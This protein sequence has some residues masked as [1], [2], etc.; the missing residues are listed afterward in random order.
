[1]DETVPTSDTSPTG[2]GTNKSNKRPLSTSQNSISEISHVV[3]PY[4]RG[5]PVTPHR[6]NATGSSLSPEHL[7]TTQPHEVS[8]STIATFHHHIKQTF[9]GPVCSACNKKI[10][11]TNVLFDI[12]RNSLRAHLTTNQCYT[13]DLSY[14]KW[15]NRSNTAQT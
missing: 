13:G 12:S 8:H 11:S 7:S 15:A 4:K 14:R 2:T 1:M 10:A 5:V 9:L 6:D 3:N